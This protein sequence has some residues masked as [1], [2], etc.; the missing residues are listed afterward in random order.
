MIPHFGMAGWMLVL[1]LNRYFSHERIGLRAAF[2]VLPRNLWVRISAM[3]AHDIPVILLVG[4]NFPR[5]VWKA[6]AEYVLPVI[7]GKVFALLSDKGAFCYRDR[8]G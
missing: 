4:P 8:H 5:C 7:R 6:P 1:G 3:L 2:G